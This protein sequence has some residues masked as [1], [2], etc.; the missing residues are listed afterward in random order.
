MR[1][2]SM[3]NRPSISHRRRGSTVFEAIVIRPDDHP[4]NRLYSQNPRPSPSEA[5]QAKHRPIN[6]TQRIYSHSSASPRS[7]GPRQFGSAIL[8]EGRISASFEDIWQS[9]SGI[10][11]LPP[12]ELH[13]RLVTRLSFGDS[14]RLWRRVLQIALRRGTTPRQCGTADGAPPGF[15][16]VHCR[17]RILFASLTLG[18]GAELPECGHECETCGSRPP[19]TS[20]CLPSGPIAPSQNS[21]SIDQ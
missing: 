18:S 8:R 16:T 14:P 15:G 5:N 12:R 11:Q 1:T 3:A 17:W 2:L 6:V 20:G 9:P 7:L 21:K 4:R 19:G 10:W 13:A